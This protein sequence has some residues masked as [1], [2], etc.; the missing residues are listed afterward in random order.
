MGPNQISDAISTKKKKKSFQANNLDFGT[1]IEAWSEMLI[2]RINDPKNLHF[3]SSLGTFPIS[4]AKV[5]GTSQ[6]HV[7]EREIFFAAENKLEVQLF[8]DLRVGLALI[9]LNTLHRYQAHDLASAWLRKLERSLAPEF[10]VLVS[11]LHLFR[12]RNSPVGDGSYARHFFCQ[13]NSRLLFR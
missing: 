6:S 8:K 3:D 10:R 4:N 12:E 5:G 7:Q 13:L 1:Q 2:I 9:S 11:R